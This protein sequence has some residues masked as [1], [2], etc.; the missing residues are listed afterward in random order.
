MNFSTSLMAPNRRV[1]L[2]VRKRRDPPTAGCGLQMV[3][4]NHQ[5]RYAIP[6]P[7]HIEELIADQMRYSSQTG[8]RIPPRLRNLEID[9][10]A[11]SFAIPQRVRFRCKLEGHDTAWHD[12]GTRRQVFYSDLR[13]GRYRFRVVACSGDGVWNEVG[14]TLEFEIMPAWYQTNWFRLLCLVS[15]GLAIWAIYGFRVRQIARVMSAR[16]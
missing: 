15:G 9:Y 10:T 6:P 3:D 16:F 14:A 8:L 2:F 12:I 1:L 5:P 13:P 7:V 4:P 11:L